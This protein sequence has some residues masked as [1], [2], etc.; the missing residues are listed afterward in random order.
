MIY[1]HNLTSL[2]LKV[3]ISHIPLKLVITQI[4]LNIF[5]INYYRETI[6]ALIIADKKLLGCQ[7]HPELSGEQ[8]LDFIDTFIKWND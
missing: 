7:F 2:I 8:G 3:F 5:E 6:L 4:I 1:T